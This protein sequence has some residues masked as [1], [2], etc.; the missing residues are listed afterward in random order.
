MGTVKLSRSN[1][2]YLRTKH[3]DFKFHHVRSLIRKK[4]ENMQYI[5]TNM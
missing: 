5:R 3:I 2:I 1:M 4:I